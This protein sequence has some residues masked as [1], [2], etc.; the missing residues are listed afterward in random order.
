[1]ELSVVKIKSMLEVDSLPAEFLDAIKLDK[2]VS[3][4]RLY[5]KWQKKQRNK[6]DEL[7][8]LEKLYQYEKQWMQQGYSMIAGV[9]EAGRGPLAGP[10][11]VA[12]AIL[13]LGCYI[14][15][16]ND[17]KKLSETK[18]NELYPIILEKALAVSSAVIGRDIIDKVNIYQATVMGM[19]EVITNLKFR[20]QAVLID[21]VK[22]DKLSVPYQSII[23][24]DALSA[25]IA[26][27]S[28][29]AKVERDRL[30]HELDSLYPVYGFA[31]HKGY[32]TAAHIKAL[33]QYG[34]CPE[35][36]ISFEPIKSML[37]A[38]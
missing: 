28:I 38:Q 3:V 27:A 5:E 16:L 2:R 10:V 25:S 19:Y 31:S 7:M 11:V 26:A 35:H 8:R 21:A 1:M 20:P 15:G 17:S 36:R 34:P 14:P 18:R 32:G 12:A 29:V 30:M 23:H 24:G 4:I 33:K 13:P 37:G 22:L 9:D 6:T